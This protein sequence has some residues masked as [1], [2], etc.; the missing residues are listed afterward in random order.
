MIAKCPRCEE[1]LYLN[2]DM[3]IA[4]GCACEMDGDDY[5]DHE[6]S[7]IYADCEYDPCPEET[8]GDIRYHEMKEEGLL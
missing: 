4:E 7:L 1:T 6:W 2:G 8:E 5:T 3:E